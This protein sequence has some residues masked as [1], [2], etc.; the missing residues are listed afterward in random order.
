MAERPNEGAFKNSQGLSL[1]CRYWYPENQ[2]VRALVHI[3]HGL[4]EHIGRYNAIASSFTKLGCAVYAHDNVGHGRSDGVRVDVEDF[5]QYIRDCLQHTDIMT[6]K[7]PNLPVIVF[8]HS[9]GGTIAI[10]MMNS[11]SS[12]FAGA[13]FGS[14]GIAPSQATPFLMLMARGVAALCPQM[15][16]GKLVVTDISRDPAV[17]EDY[18]KDPL[19]WHGGVKARWAV[20]MYD[21]CMKIQAECGEKANYPFLLQHG[22]K[23]N[24]CDIKGS[25]LFFERSKSQ[26][27][28]YKIYE[29]YFHELDKEPEGE[30]EV[31]FKD[32]EEWTS[33]FLERLEGSNVD[34]PTRKVNPDDV[35]LKT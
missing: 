2:D 26:N 35:D 34:D 8:G 13:I 10:L 14:P 30:R 21:A 12:R 3:I 6:E 17:V 7:Y 15:S 27:K 23:D 24:L 11:H 33:N 25:D 22:S 31:V 1:H 28:V 32:L 20:N 4:G 19:V 9:M 16:V 5:Q 29:G 18:V